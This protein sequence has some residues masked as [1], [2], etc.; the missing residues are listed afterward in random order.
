VGFVFGRQSLKIQIP[1][2]EAQLVARRIG[3]LAETEGGLA[4]ALVGAARRVSF[5]TLLGEGSSGGLRAEV[6]V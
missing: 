4:G 5:R 3:R 1:A 6:V 2:R